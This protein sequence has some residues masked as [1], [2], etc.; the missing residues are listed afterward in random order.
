LKIEIRFSFFC[1]WIKD[2]KKVG[3]MALK[4]KQIKSNLGAWAVPKNIKCKAS[5]TMQTWHHEK[6]NSSKNNCGN[7]RACEQGDA[8]YLL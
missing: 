8:R 1:H 5:G 6:S 7:L 3:A 4:D 2:C